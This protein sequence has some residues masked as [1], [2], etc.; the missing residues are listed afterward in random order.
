MN[1]P[2]TQISSGMSLQG[3]QQ[4]SFAQQAVNGFSGNTS[5][6]NMSGTS[7]SGQTSSSV[8]AQTGGTVS[9]GSGGG[10]AMCSYTATTVAPK[11]TAINNATSTK[12]SAPSGTATVSGGMCVAPSSSSGA[13]TGGSSSNATTTQATSSNS[14]TSILSNV[15]SYVT[16]IWNSFTSI[17]RR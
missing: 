8:N 15:V 7:T 12:A 9:G 14:S 16:S 4:N 13:K 3:F 17:L 1:N 5:L 6:I 2:I 10:S 11:A